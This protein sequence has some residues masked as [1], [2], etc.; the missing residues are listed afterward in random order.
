[1]KDKKRFV[2]KG[3]TIFVVVFA[4]ILIALTML[5]SGLSKVHNLLIVMGIV[6]LE[7]SLLYG[8]HL[9]TTKASVTDPLTGL[10]TR[11]KFEHE[12]EILLRENPHK[13][14]MLLEADIRGFKFLNHNYGDEAA[15]EILQA[16]SKVLAEEVWENG[17]LLGRGYADRFYAIFIIKNQKTAMST[18]QA[19][20]N[21]ILESV[22]TSEF[23]YFPKFG[24]TLYFP[25]KHGPLSNH[26]LVDLIGQASLAKST[27]KKDMVTPYAI[28]N[29]QIQ[30]KADEDQFIES[31]MEKALNEGEFFVMYQPKVSLKTDKIVGA[32]ALV[33]W[34]SSKLGLLTPSQFVPLFEQNGFIVNLDFFVYDQVFK[35]IQKQLDEGKPIVP[36]SV[37]MS[38][39]H[40]NPER[41]IGR[42]MKIFNKYNI[43]ANLVEVEILE[44]SFDNG[45]LLLQ[46][47]TKQLHDYGFTVAMDDFGSGESSLNMLQ[48]ISIDVLKFDQNFLRNSQLEKDPAN[49]IETLV[50]LGKNMNI[51]TI[52][53]GVET[54]EQRNYLKTLDCD[55]VQGFFYSHP[56]SQND[57]EN[58]L[59]F[60]DIPLSE[61][62]G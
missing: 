4:F 9:S 52:F 41:F 45:K 26:P 53:E 11:Q 51:K 33:R 8:F 35:F 58:F 38:R 62:A 44:R 20:L 32:E 28:Y 12:A 23:P 25:E 7:L 47:V 30:R 54:E 43:P 56:L 50:E 59:R 19:C 31:N 49:M 60:A 29:S 6:T 13:R 55:E 48:N 27:I 36:I 61:Q 37:N 34:K 16:F 1:M 17:G 5:T 21:K 42:F 57:F 14:F 46:N 10:W 15:N 18:F 39:S 24:L 3:L 40:I 2:S 22:K